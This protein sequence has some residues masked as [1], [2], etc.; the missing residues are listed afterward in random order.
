MCIFMYVQLNHFGL[1]LK[2]M[3]H[4]KLTVLQFLKNLILKNQI[5]FLSKLLSL[6]PAFF[7]S[8]VPLL[9]VTDTQELGDGFQFPWHQHPSISHAIA[10]MYRF[11]FFYTFPLTSFSA[12]A[13]HHLSSGPP[14]R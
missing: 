12:C 6:L 4:C 14:D 8:G 11:Y 1:Y 5:Y 7:Q 10:K 13:Q 3:Q 2:L 9:S